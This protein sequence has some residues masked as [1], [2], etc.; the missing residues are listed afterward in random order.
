MREGPREPLLTCRARVCVL[1]PSFVWPFCR[2]GEEASRAAMKVYRLCTVLLALLV[3]AELAAAARETYRYNFKGQKKGGGDGAQDSAEDAP[4]PE[5]VSALDGAWKRVDYYDL[6]GLPHDVDGLTARDV[7]KA[8]RRTARVHHPDKFADA[9]K[10][11]AEEQR[12]ANKR[13]ARLVDAM[14]CLKSREKRENYE[15]LL[16]NG[17]WD[18][19]EVDWE[20]WNYKKQK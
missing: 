2:R 12:E 17:L 16:K 9:T 20:N 19:T 6:L 13:F 15:E 14:E 10:Y 4:P 3:C 7:V 5:P 8:Y 1:R 18:Y 11:S